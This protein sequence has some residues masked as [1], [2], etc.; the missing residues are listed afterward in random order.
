M[1][2]FFL[3]L[4]H[5]SNPSALCGKIREAGTRNL[6]VEGWSW[7]HHSACEA[8]LSDIQAQLCCYSPDA[9]TAEMWV[10]INLRTPTSCSHLNH[11]LFPELYNCNMGGECVCVWGELKPLLFWWYIVISICLLINIITDLVLCLLMIRNRQYTVTI[12]P[13]EYSIAFSPAPV[14]GICITLK[15]TKDISNCIAFGAL[16]WKC[17]QRNFWPLKGELSALIFP[18]AKSVNIQHP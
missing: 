3:I 6:K 11:L 4:T 10:R 9:H 18:I 12:Y 16:H 14:V 5:I 1:V 8:E 7:L 13:R 2:G 15:S 17:F